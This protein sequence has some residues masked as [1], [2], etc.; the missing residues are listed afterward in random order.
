[1][2]TMDERINRLELAVIA[3]DT[4]FDDMYPLGAQHINPL[5]STARRD[6]ARLHAQIAAS[7]QD[8]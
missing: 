5:I 3:I 8:P 4:V 1:M 7:R 2:T 6:L